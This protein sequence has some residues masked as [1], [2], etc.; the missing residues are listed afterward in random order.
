MKAVYESIVWITC[1]SDYVK[2]LPKD[3]RDKPD[4]ESKFTLEQ[5][6]FCW[7]CLQ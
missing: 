2:H 1:V 5:Q 4:A 6:R 3:S 7:W